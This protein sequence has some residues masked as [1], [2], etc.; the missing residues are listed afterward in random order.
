MWRECRDARPAPAGPPLSP[1]AS[2]WTQLDR[3]LDEVAARGARPVIVISPIAN[4]RYDG[5]LDEVVRRYSSR[6]RLID[7]R[8]HFPATRD[9]FADRM[10]LNAAGAVA[11][12]RR[13]RQ[14]LEKPEAP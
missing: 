1:P 11:W 14:L 13:L 10:H 9:H 3:L 5:F 2:F 8:G 4:P 7:D 12:S 6:C